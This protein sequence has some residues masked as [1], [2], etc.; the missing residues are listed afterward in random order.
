MS[1]PTLFS[2]PGQDAIQPHSQV[3]QF[4]VRNA[5]SKGCL[6]R[7]GLSRLRACTYSRRAPSSASLRVGAPLLLFRILDQPPGSTNFPPKTP[8]FNHTQ[9]RRRPPSGR[10][11]SISTAPLHQ[12][13]AAAAFAVAVVGPLAAPAGAAAPCCGLQ[14]AF[15]R[16]RYVWC[17]GVRWMMDC[18]TCADMLTYRSI[19]RTSSSGAAAAAAGA[20]G[21]VAGGARAAAW[22]GG[23][24]IL[25]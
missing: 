13:A 1:P 15:G 25:G 20:G 22:S 12:H 23:G 18:F 5:R 19:G 11:P 16:V 9:E 3:D 21:S 17:V 6:N 2:W 14:G 4:R 10:T 7:W 24:A 8:P